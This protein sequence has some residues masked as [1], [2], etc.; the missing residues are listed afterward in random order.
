MNKEEFIKEYEEVMGVEL[1]AKNLVIGLVLT[2]A[3]MAILWAG[4]AIG[5]SL[6]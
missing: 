5:N 2:V 3:F 4:S 6:L 1:N